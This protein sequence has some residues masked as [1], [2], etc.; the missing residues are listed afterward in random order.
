MFKR[1]TAPIAALA[2][3]VL[4]TGLVFASHQ[5]PDV[6]NSNQ[7]HDDIAWLV[8]SGIANG[9]TNGNFGPRDS[10]SRQAMAHFLHEYNEAFPPEPGPA[11]PQARLARSGG[12]PGP[13][14]PVGPDGPVGPADGPVGP[15]GGGPWSRRRGRSR[16]PGWRGS[17]RQVRVVGSPVSDTDADKGESYTDAAGCPAGK[18]VLG[19]G[20]SIVENSSDATIVQVSSFPS[21]RYGVD[22]QGRSGHGQ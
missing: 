9:Y 4:G 8:D 22:L 3:T 2:I 6:P 13:A 11:G 1:A 15:A 14:G 18:V 7:F 21:S 17:R 12:P 19:G 10:V 5:F 16:R 20:G